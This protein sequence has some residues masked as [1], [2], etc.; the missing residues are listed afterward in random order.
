MDRRPYSPSFQS[1]GR[2]NGSFDDSSSTPSS[3]SS[4]SDHSWEHSSVSKPKS[5]RR[6][7]GSKAS[8]TTSP[9]HD[10]PMTKNDL[11]FSLDCEMVGVG[12]EG[13]DSA[14]ARVA[15]CNWAEEVILD[16]Y[17]QVPTE[18]TDYRTFVSGI[19]AKDL[20]GSDVMP[21]EQVRCLVKNILHGKIL[22]GHALE[23]DLA[24]LKITHPWHDIRDTASYPPF[25]KEIRDGE[26]RSILRPRKLKELA[27][28]H[29][30]RDIQAQGEAHNPVEDARTALRLYK[31][32][33]MQWELM[34]MAQ[35]QA[36]ARE[37]EGREAKSSVRGQTPSLNSS[38]QPVSPRRQ[39]NQPKAFNYRLSGYATRN[40]TCASSW[41]YGSYPPSYYTNLNCPDM[42]FY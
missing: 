36:S 10:K 5:R 13:L 6:R 23:N 22:I 42:S 9:P 14:V 3:P 39:S 4:A 27:W 15:I 18:I 41:G 25:M 24:A 20:E 35:V 7:H 40:H 31:S 17:V 34:V 12:P 11:Y 29:L 8:K 28:D 37:E 32:V 33:R 21:L 26:D 1:R 16:T 19:E 30:G 38:S 2:R